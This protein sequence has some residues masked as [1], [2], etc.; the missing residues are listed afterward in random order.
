M[1]F[2]DS[3]KPFLH[4]HRIAVL[5]VL[6]DSGEL[7]GAALHYAW[8]EMNGVFVFFTRTG[9]VKFQALE[10]GPKQASLVI[11]FSDEEFCT[12][13]MRGEARICTNDA[14]KQAYCEKYRHI[15]EFLRDSNAAFI[16]FQPT[17]YRYSDLRQN[18]AAKISSEDSKGQLA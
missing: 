5:S 11:G 13:Q 6:L 3:I 1:K 7:H 14:A 8:D 12:I 18:P 10:K 9:T 15:L 16:E 17:W 2:A 4:K